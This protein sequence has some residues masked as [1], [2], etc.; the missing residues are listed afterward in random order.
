M[1][2]K[3]SSEMIVIHNNWSDNEEENNSNQASSSGSQSKMLIDHGEVDDSCS[4]IS[5]EEAD[6]TIRKWKK[7]NELKRKQTAKKTDDPQREKKA[8]FYYNQLKNQKRK[9]RK[10]KKVTGKWMKGHCEQKNEPDLDQDKRAQEKLLSS[11][12]DLA[13]LIPRSSFEMI[14]S[15]IINLLVE[16]T[17]LYAKRDRNKI[18]FSI[19]KEEI[20]F[21][22]FIFLSSYNIIKIAR[23]YWSVDPHLGC[24]SFRKTMSRNRFE[25][26]KS[27]F[28]V[29][30][31]TFLE[32]DSRMSKVKPIY[33]MINEK[34]VQFG[35]L[36]KSLS[37]GE[38][39][40]PYFS[41]HRNQFTLASNFGFLSAQQ[42]CRTIF[43]S[44]KGS[45]LIK[46]RT[47]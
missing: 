24:S 7:K 5:D 46:M 19:S 13:E 44:M 33:D 47:H 37:V 32:Q 15:D 25:E 41:R 42:V 2:N 16:Q 36:H 35:I 17:N 9:Q 1:F 40:V 18:N 22:G 30:D 27:V 26:I 39:M 8:N 14:F 4:G 29:A 3:V 10:E 12:P 20:N 45:L 23:D 21:T 31:N 11:N 28:H 34:I 38:S 43:A 6:Y